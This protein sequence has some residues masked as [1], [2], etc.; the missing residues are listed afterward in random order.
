MA[1][2]YDGPDEA[3]FT[4]D[5][6]A[7]AQHLTFWFQMALHGAVEIGWYDGRSEHLSKSARFDLTNLEDAVTFIAATNRVPGQSV[8]FRPALINETAPSPTTDKAFLCAPG[9][10]ADLDAD[11]AAI[12]APR[13]YSACRPNLVVVTGREPALRAQLFWRTES[14]YWDGAALRD[15]N[16]RIAMKLLGDTKVMSTLMRIGGTIAWPRKPGRVFELTELLLFADDRPKA[17]VAGAIERFFPP[18][19]AGASPG[20]GAGA[21][22]EGPGAA[23]GGGPDFD[24]GLTAAALIARIRRGKGGWHNDVLRLVAHLVEVGTS[25][26]V[27]LAM[28][29]GLTL[30]GWTAEQTR[31]DIW[32]MADAARRKWGT[33]D[34][35]APIDEPGGA[36]VDDGRLGEWN[37][38]TVDDVPIPPRGWVLGR[39]LCRGVV[40]SL[41]AEGGVGKTALRMV[42]ALAVVTGKALTG[43]PVHCMGRVLYLSLEDD[44][45]ELKRRLKAAMIHHQISA[46][47]VRDRF[48]LATPRQWKLA[49]LDAKGNFKVGELRNRVISTIREHRIDVVV[50]DPFVKAHGVGEND[51]NAIDQ[52]TGILADIAITE[53][54]AVDAPHHMSKGSS[55]PGNANRGRGASAFKDA[56]RL[57]YTLTPMSKDEGQEMGLPP[58]LASH[59]I[60]MDRGKVNLAP[61]SYG[62]TWFRLVGVPI[63]NGDEVQTVE[64]WYPADPRA[65][66]TPAIAAAILSEIDKGLP[67][68]ERYSEHNRADA[69]AAWKVI[70]KHAPATSEAAAKRIIKQ[71]IDLGVLV[72]RTYT[73]AGRWEPVTGLYVDPAKAPL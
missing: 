28:A 55:D 44:D 60:R 48:Y 32:R 16:R 39:I 68:G 35:D 7:I 64:R 26:A 58:D 52:V 18:A 56:A 12:A 11:G 3:P 31:R 42:Q 71:W 45:V 36:P 2:T 25:D 50:F 14:L 22:G 20:A 9:V 61:P 19:E 47:D 23:P 10:W 1:Q 59:L 43:E 34:P 65:G 4:P 54:V 21:A 72:V 38:G 67:K 5:E 24:P 49:T 37:A 27:I 69:R 13:I 46:D 41:I 8:Y 57:V 30:P 15:L 66:I 17:Y 73:S 63:G 53:N 6:K 40:S 62:A 33:A 29:E 70:L 51:N